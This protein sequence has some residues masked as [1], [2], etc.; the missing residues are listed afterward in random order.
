MII[1]KET[2][3]AEALKDVISCIDWGD[4]Q[5]DELQAFA[6]KLWAECDRLETKITPLIV[7]CGHKRAISSTDAEDI[8]NLGFGVTNCS[9]EEFLFLTKR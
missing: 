9:A 8:Y 3:S 4:W 2:S 7:V 1:S 6:D 5:L